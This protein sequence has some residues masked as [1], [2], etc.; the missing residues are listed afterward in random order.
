MCHVA[1]ALRTDVESS[2]CVPEKTPEL[3]P[4]KDEQTRG[5]PSGLLISF[6]EAVS[7]IAAAHDRQSAESLIL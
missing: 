4:V 1:V 3:I 6:V 2:G 5:L 7:L